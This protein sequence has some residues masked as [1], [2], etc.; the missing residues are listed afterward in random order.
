M[1]RIRFEVR[2]CKSGILKDISHLDIVRLFQRA[3]RRAEVPVML[4]E[5]FTPHYRIGFGDALKL[6]RESEDEKAVFT[7][8]KW[9]EPEEFKNRINEKLPEEIQIR[10]TMGVGLP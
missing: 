8:E 1:Q 9:I 7:M 5:G 6:G 2:F 10:K 4:S 3:V